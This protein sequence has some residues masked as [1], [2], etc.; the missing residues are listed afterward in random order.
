[1]ST[2]TVTEVKTTLFGERHEFECDLLRAS[3]G[4]AVVIYRIPRDLLLE[5]VFLPKDTISV[6]YF[7][8]QMPFNAYHWIDD[9][10]DT[11][12]LYF[13]VCDNTKISTSVIEWRDLV[14]DIL[15]TA[16]GRCRVLD[17]N[18]L[19]KDLDPKLLNYIEATRDDLCRDPQ[20]RLNEFD[21]STRGLIKLQ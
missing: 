1:M 10:Q 16:D 4:E 9:H 14:V 15:M 12:A 20:S 17:E 11:L 21:H 5:D 2:A 19:P 6:G 13:N 7:W 18:E 3:S 8:Q